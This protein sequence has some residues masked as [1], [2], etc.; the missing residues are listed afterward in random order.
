MWQHYCC[1]FKTARYY[2]SQELWD[3]FVY[4]SR[5]WI[6]GNHVNAG[7]TVPYTALLNITFCYIISLIMYNTYNL[8]TWL[9]NLFIYFF[10]VVTQDDPVI[11]IHRHAKLKLYIY[12]YIYMCVYNIL[13][14]IHI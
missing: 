1:W 13:Y 12:I 3:K 4:L 7:I 2:M 6:L 9:Y 11:E 10:L 14:L 8:P 5:L